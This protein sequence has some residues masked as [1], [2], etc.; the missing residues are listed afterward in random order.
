MASSIDPRLARWIALTD[1]LSSDLLGGPRWIKLAWVINAQKGGTLPFVLGL[2][3]WY[4]TWTSAAWVY[5]ALHGSYGLAWLIKD[6]AF[7][8]PGWQR[9]VTFAA[10]MSSF[11]LVLGPYWLAPWLLISGAAGVP[12]RP[13]WLLGLAA[14]LYGVGVSIMLAAD[15]Q[16]YFTLQHRPGLITT[17]MFRYVRHPNYLGEMLIYGAFALV[18]GHWAPWLVLA[19]V[20]GGLFVPNMIRKEASMS[21]HAEWA[22]YRARTGWIIPGW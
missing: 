16:K 15:A 20:W 13:P 7:P 14:F 8:D 19:W 3:W 12:E 11:A 2:M 18:A 1:Y 5:A 17:G 22:G 6:F 21:R 9:R 10:G 4:D